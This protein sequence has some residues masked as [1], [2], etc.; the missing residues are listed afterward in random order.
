MNIILLGPPGVGK[1]TYA[2]ELSN[3]LEIPHIS[4]GELLREITKQDTEQGKKIKEIIDKG[5]LVP[6]ELTT[7]ILKK[8]LKK[9]DCKNGFILDGYPRT[10]PQAGALKKIAKIDKVIDYVAIDKTILER[11]SGRLTC[12]K[13]GAIFHVKNIPPKKEGICDKCGGELYTREDQT[14][15]A[16]KKRL[17]VYREQTEP[18]IEYYQKE[19]LLSEV[20]ANA[21]LSQ[22]DKII[23][24]SL[25]IIEGEE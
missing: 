8:R 12:K 19:N 25:D 13:C 10:T 22:I 14:E 2:E 4:T 1:G 24:E 18:L 5:N 21:G 3:R 17:N 11:L 7:D 23:G 6:D 20:D 16:I 15:E 9:D